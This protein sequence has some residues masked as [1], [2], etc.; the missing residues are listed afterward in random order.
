MKFEVKERGAKVPPIE[1]ICQPHG[2]IKKK[3]TNKYITSDL[4]VRSS[5]IK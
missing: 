1:I 5:S 2:M 4:Q 3:K